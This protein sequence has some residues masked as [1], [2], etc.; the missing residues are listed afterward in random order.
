[1]RCRARAR[2][3]AEELAN[4]P[5]FAFGWMKHLMLSAF[6]GGLET[7][8]ALERRGAVEAARRAELP[9]GIRAFLAKRPAQFPPP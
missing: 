6:S 8:L 7:Q 5:T 2:A 4:G 1:M 9:E 3:R